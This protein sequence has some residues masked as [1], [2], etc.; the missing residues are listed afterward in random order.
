MIKNY[1]LKY[2]KPRKLV[3]L[4]QKLILKKMMF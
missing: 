2:I 4:V 1:S 3:F